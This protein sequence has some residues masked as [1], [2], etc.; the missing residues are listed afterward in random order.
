MSTT[1]ARER[2]SFG[3]FQLRPS[4]LITGGNPYRPGTPEHETFETARH[5]PDTTVRARPSEDLAPADLRHVR[6]VVAGYA[7]DTD[8]LAQLLAVLGL[9]E[10]QSA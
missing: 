10:E 9:D 6:L 1:S 2:T 8:D 4:H 5:F 7:T 3:N